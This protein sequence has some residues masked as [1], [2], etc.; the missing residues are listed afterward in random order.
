MVFSNSM[1]GPTNCAMSLSPVEI[2]TLKPASAP[3]FASVPITSSASTPGTRSSG[4]PIAA[5]VSKKRLHLR[6]QIV[7]HGRA[8]RLVLIE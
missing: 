6:A 2:S 4:T 5:T 1:F 3:C 8:M 7:R